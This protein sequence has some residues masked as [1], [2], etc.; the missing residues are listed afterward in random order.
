MTTEY[1]EIAIPQ[2]PDIPPEIT[3]TFTELH[4]HLI[5]ISERLNDLEERIATLEAA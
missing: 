3:Q 2:G 5:R 4:A 1:Y